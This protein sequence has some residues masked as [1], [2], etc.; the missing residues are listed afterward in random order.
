MTVKDKAL[1]V[2]IIRLD[3]IEYFDSLDMYF[4]ILKEIE[5][6]G[7]NMTRSKFTWIVEDDFYS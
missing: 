5:K 4:K 2:M 7:L 3:N 1:P 6:L